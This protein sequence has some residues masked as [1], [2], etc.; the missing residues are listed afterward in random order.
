MKTSKASALS[1][2][3]KIYTRDKLVESNIN[4]AIDLEWLDM[5]VLVLNFAESLTSSSY[6]LGEET[7]FYEVLDDPSF[8]GW[9][10]YEN[11]KVILTYN[12]E[13]LYLR[14]ISDSLIQTFFF[15]YVEGDLIKIFR[16]YESVS[17]EGNSLYIEDFIEKNSLSMWSGKVGGQNSYDIYSRV[18]SED[19]GLY[20][21]H[22]SSSSEEET[23]TNANYNIDGVPL[24]VRRITNEKFKINYDFKFVEVFDSFNV[25]GLLFLNNEEVQ[26]PL[27]MRVAPPYHGSDRYTLIGAKEL[28]DDDIET[29]I[30]IIL[31]SPV[32]GISYDYS[33]GVDVILNDLSDILYLS[34]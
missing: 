34:Y 31:N 13:V 17:S 23:F 6:I 21:F 15:E 30:N 28:M 7:L 26:V 12:E 10:V 16:L 9:A 33:L 8:W 11:T 18:L 27:E 32:N 1:D 2:A 19:D 22:H 25:E 20:T 14:V 24:N 5:A 29:N 3:T 4:S